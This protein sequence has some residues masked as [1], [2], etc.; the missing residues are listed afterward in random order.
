[1]EILRNHWKSIEIIEILQ[2]SS[3]I[4]QNPEEIMG[5][6]LKSLKSLRNHRESIEILRKSS[7]MH[8]IHRN[9]QEIIEKSSKS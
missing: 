4:H 5:N 8:G 3:E 1:M 2:K 9:P 6:P 7:E